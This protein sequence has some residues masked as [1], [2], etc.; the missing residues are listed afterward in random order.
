MMYDSK[1][2]KFELGDLV[3]Y[4]NLSQIKEMNSYGITTG[5][6]TGIV[7]DVMDQDPRTNDTSG[8]FSAA[9]KI[10]WLNDQDPI[11]YN[12][13]NIHHLGYITI[14][15]RATSHGANPQFDNA[16][17]DWGNRETLNTTSDARESSTIHNLKSPSAEPQ[18]G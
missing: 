17:P 10:R 4:E 18:L 14:I 12:G 8:A 6:V 2:Q 9:V 3:R 15:A 1:K 16:N 7:I 13:Y 5:P 11:W